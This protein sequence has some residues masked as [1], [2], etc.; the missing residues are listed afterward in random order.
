MNNKVCI[1]CKRPLSGNYQDEICPECLDKN[2][3]NEVRDYIRANNVTEYQVAE[4]FNIP[5]RKVR[6]W[7]DED[8]IQ[9]V[10]PEKGIALSGLRCLECKAYIKE[11]YYCEKCKKKRQIF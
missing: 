6:R 3:F 8:R 5:L 7:I 10:F 2:L 9:Y 4:H 11:G 1:Q